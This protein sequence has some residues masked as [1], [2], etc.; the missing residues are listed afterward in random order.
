MRR[1]AIWRSGE[2][3]AS[4]GQ[5]PASSGQTTL[6][7]RQ[8]HGCTKY[9]PS[10]DKMTAEPRCMNG[11]NALCCGGRTR[12][13][14]T[15]PPPEL[16]H[17]RDH[18]GHDGQLQGVEGRVQVLVDLLIADV[19]NEAHDEGPTSSAH[20]GGDGERQ[21]AS[22]GE[23]APATLVL[24][25]GAGRRRLL[26]D[27]PHLRGTGAGSRDRRHESRPASHGLVPQQPR[28]P[29]EHAPRRSTPDVGTQ[30]TS[31]AV[32]HIG[33]R[34]DRHIAVTSST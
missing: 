25:G 17:V 11:H 9:V 2:S 18:D 27:G 23:H 10:Q 31:H 7:T 12:A 24:R 20:Q 29:V 22:G 15:T 28:P 33:R 1:N 16:E 19:Q 4:G 30:A 3:Q 8:H 6:P 21:R 32:K 13:S 14:L 26:L 5:S 34:C